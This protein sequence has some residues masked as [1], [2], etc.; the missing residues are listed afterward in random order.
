LSY[1]STLENKTGMDAVNDV[2]TSEFLNTIVASG[3]S[4]H[5]LR[6]KVGVPVMLRNIDKSLGLCNGTRLVI[7]R[8]G[9]FVLEG[10]VISGSN[11]GDKVFI[12]RLS[13]TRLILES[14]SSFKESNFR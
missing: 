14:L 6:L 3:L 13:L 12:P 1:D 4:N 11:I 2:H 5:K 9:K 10:K 8:M 7:K